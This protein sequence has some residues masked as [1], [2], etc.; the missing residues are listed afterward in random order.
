[1]RIISKTAV[2]NWLY[3]TAAGKRAGVI[4]ESLKHPLFKTVEIETIS[5]CNRKCVYCPNHS[6]ERPA[7]LMEE[8]VFYKLID[9]LAD[10][11]FSGT[12]SPHFYGEPMLDKRLEKFKN[13]KIS[14]LKNLK[15][16]RI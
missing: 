15:Y 16:L 14:K 11:G 10:I 3:S 6:Y 5:T 12:L 1:M 7:G 4:F 8:A 9:E 13:V 2:K